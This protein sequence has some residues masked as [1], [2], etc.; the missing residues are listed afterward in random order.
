MNVEIGLESKGM[1]TVPQGLKRSATLGAPMA[2]MM[3]SRSSSV[4]RQRFS[5]LPPYLS[6]RKFTLELRNW[7]QR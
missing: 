3:A 6:V 1:R 5:M 4:K 7:S 2:A